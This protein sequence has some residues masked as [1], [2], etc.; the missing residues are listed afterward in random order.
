[1]RIYTNLE[2]GLHELISAV[3]ERGEP[4]S[5][6]LSGI[7]SKNRQWGKRDR[8]FLWES[9]F[10]FFK[11]YRLIS[12]VLQQPE[13]SPAHL[14]ATLT[15]SFILFLKRH[16]SFEEAAK[17]LELAGEGFSDM[18][19][20]SIPDEWM[21]F[22]S[23]SQKLTGAV[24]QMRTKAS[25]GLRVNRL[26][27]TPEKVI[28]QL[29]QE[30]IAADLLPLYPDAVLVQGHPK[31][32]QHHLIAE[33]FCEVQDAGSQAVAAFCMVEPE[34]NVLDA[35]CG[36]GG[37]SLHLAALMN[38]CG[39]LVCGDVSAHKLKELSA[40]S[41][42]AGVG[43]AHPVNWS[44]HPEFSRN[45]FH[46]VLIDAPCSGSGT[47]KREPDLRLRITANTLQKTI[48]LQRDLMNC[49]AEAVAAGGMLIYAS[50]SIFRAENESQVE[51]FLE[52]HPNFRLEEMKSLMPTAHND[53]FY[54]ARMRKE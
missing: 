6:A 33:G 2:K 21:E 25:L 13:A 19:K 47:L 20:L 44:E 9:T 27:T 51:R 54:M 43:I 18:I 49:Y 17:E 23:D 37:K 1:M 39:N 35:C 3:V 32:D 8:D 29:K 16:E 15:E 28:Q 36:A 34:M 24:R 42:R 10:L 53:G 40:R 5:Y 46:R 14:P 26:K 52:T 50:C 22:E 48:L 30:N 41:R 38:N 11:N 12:A 45:H 31:L 7:F 4:L